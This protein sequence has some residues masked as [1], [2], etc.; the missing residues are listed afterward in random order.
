MRYLYL[1][2]FLAF[3]YTASGKYAKMGIPDIIAC[4]PQ[5]IFV[6]IETKRPGEK[7]RPTQEAYINAYNSLGAVAFSATSVEEVEN[8]LKE[9]GLICPKN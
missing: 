7:P 2:G 4:S 8:K 1:H 6:A 5:G 3:V 9:R